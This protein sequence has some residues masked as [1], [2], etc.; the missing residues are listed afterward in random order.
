MLHPLITDW[1]IQEKIKKKKKEKIKY[2][3]LKR[4]L[5][6]VKTESTE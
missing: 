6:N 5:K 4:G 1:E 2:L 3:Q